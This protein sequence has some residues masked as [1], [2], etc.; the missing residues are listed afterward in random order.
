METP[1]GSAA[2]GE[3]Q[4]NSRRRVSEARNEARNSEPR[5]A[6]DVDIPSDVNEIEHVV[7]LVTALCRDLS[8]PKR[9]YTLNVPVALSE[10][11][12]NAIIRGNHEDPSKH[13][14]LRATVSE[15]ALVIDVSDEG[16]GFDMHGTA[17]D[18][19]SPEHLQREDGRGLFLMRQLM[20]NVEQVNG[21]RHVLRLTLNR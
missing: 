15:L 16:S 10:A 11:L 12:S 8:L 4:S 3:G 5:V 7:S 13:V 9:H 18:P 14:H 17:H 21:P 2:A 6:V 19:T 1:S 20:D